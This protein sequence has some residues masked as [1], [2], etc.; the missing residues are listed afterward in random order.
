MGPA[1]P[2]LVSSLQRPEVPGRSQPTV[3]VRSI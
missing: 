3:G 1:T 2:R